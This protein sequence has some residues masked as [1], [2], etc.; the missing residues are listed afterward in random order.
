MAQA[1]A[2]VDVGRELV[3]RRLALISSLLVIAVLPALPGGASERDES[4]DGWALLPIND[5]VPPNPNL[6]GWSYNDVDRFILAALEQAELGPAPDADRYR[7]LRRVTFD[8]T[9]LPP[10]PEAIGAFV[11]D[12]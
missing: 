4:L 2:V 6:T 7:L 9:G 1:T 10:T 12:Q 5:P 11:A 8:L 3:V